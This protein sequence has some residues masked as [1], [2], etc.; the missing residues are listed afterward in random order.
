MASGSV[1]LLKNVA[2]IPR[3]LMPLYCPS[4]DTSSAAIAK[5][6]KAVKLAAA[7]LAAGNKSDKEPHG[8]D[9]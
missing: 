1:I 4:G 6:L 9:Y 7:L 2:R 8:D 3:A 5:K